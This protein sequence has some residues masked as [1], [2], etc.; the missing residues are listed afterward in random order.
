ML[1]C[2]SVA[3][4]E[5]RVEMFYEI[6]EMGIGYSSDPVTF[7]PSL[8]PGERLIG[9]A[10]ARKKK[11]AEAIAELQAKG[12]CLALPYDVSVSDCDLEAGIPAARFTV[13]GYAI[14]RHRYVG[15]CVIEQTGIGS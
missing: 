9:C 6:N 1:F 2:S 15:F 5:S 4:A 13:H 8:K 11:L 14:Y 3:L 12:G 10:V 7:A